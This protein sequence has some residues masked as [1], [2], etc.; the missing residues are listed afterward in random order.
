MISPDIYIENPRTIY[1]HKYGRALKRLPYWSARLASLGKLYCTLTLVVYR[2]HWYK[3]NLE[4]KSSFHQMMDSVTILPNCSS[5][6]VPATSQGHYG[7]IVAL[8]SVQR[9]QIDTFLYHQSNFE[10]TCRRSTG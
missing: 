6:F 7:R 2:V 9:K 1:M 8:T 10:Q 4:T 5:V 3:T